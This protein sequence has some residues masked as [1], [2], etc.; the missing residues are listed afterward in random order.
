MEYQGYV[1]SAYY[2]DSYKGTIIPE[3]V[4]EQRLMLA[5]HDID[6][7]TYNRIVRTSFDKL[8]KFQQ[9][10]IKKSV[11]MH[12]DFIYQFGDYINSPISGYSAGTISVS[13]KD[14][15][16]A[17]QNGVMTTKSTF[18]MLKQTGLTVRLFA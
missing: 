1:D 13:F 4:L 18:A 12:A 6:S 16:I 17:G 8:T 3:D 14:L 9:S 7:L 15:N 5:S 2:K 11:C 10:I